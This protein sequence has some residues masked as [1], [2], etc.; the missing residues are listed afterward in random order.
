MKLS[1]DILM[2]GIGKMIYN[3]KDKVM[4]RIADITEDN[5]HKPN[6]LILSCDA[7]PEFGSKYFAIPLTKTFVKVTDGGK[8]VLNVKKDDLNNVGAIDFNRS[9]IIKRKNVLQKIYELIDY[10]GGI[11]LQIR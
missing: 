3:T 11:K 6:Y 1:K 4:G 10:N 9:S 8:M 7:F 5:K 2:N